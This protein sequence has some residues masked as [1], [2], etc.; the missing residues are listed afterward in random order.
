[1]KEDRYDNR[2]PSQI[3]FQARANCMALNERNRH[4][5]GGETSCEICGEEEL[6]NLGH[7]LLACGSLDRERDDEVMERNSGAT[8]E[9][10]IGNILWKEEDIERVKEMIGKMWQRRAVLRKRMGL[11]AR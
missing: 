9:E 6:E 1:M 10:W 8:A 3:L 4:R 2:R 7:F 5:E 11:S